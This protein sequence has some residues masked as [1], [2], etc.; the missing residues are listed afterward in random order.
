[1]KRA[2]QLFDGLHQARS[3]AIDGIADDDD[4]S[5]A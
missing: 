4:V 1:M 3:R 5:A 2:G